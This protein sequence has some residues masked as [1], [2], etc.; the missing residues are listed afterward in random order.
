MLLVIL[1]LTVTGSGESVMMMDKS[2][3]VDE[4]RREIVERCIS[5]NDRWSFCQ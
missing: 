1:E 5:E 3:V 2:A 4:L